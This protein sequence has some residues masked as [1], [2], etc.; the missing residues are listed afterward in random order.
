L[1]EVEG[2][3]NDD[4]ERV[5]AA[6]RVVHQVVEAEVAELGI[7]TAVAETHAEAADGKH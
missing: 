4:R 3:V 1:V 5:S 6:H 2:I 7:G